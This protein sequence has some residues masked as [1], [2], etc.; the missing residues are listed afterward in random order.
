MSRG[1]TGNAIRCSQVHPRVSRSLGRGIE[2]LP[3][4]GHT[5][6]RSLS[7]SGDVFGRT[8]GEG[9]KREG[10]VGNTPGHEGTRRHE[11]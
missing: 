4:I 1:V 6:G 9:R 5:L 2:D 11:I 10:R 3:G 7:A 8:Q